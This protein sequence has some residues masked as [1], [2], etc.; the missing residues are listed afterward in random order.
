ME[1]S[2]I[3]NGGVSGIHTV[4]RGSQGTFIKPINDDPRKRQS[5]YN[6][7]YSAFT[8]YPLTEVGELV[9]HAPAP[10]TNY[11][12]HCS[13]EIDGVLTWVPVTIYGEALSTSGQ[14]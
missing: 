9:F 6:G 1:L 2:S 10:Y 12:A 8:Y 13:V 14:F 11:V 3:S 5:Y 4:A 7:N